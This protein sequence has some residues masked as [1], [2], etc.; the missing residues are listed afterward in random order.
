MI[1]EKLSERVE[2]VFTSC[3]YTFKTM[4][5]VERTLDSTEFAL[6]NCLKEPFLFNLGQQRVGLAEHFLRAALDYTVLFER[7]CIGTVF[8]FLF[9]IF[10]GTCLADDGDADL[11]GVGELRLHGPGDIAAEQHG[12]FVVHFLAV[13]DDAQIAAGLDGVGFFHAGEAVG[14]VFQ[15]LKP[16][17]V[18]LQHFLAGAGPGTGKRI[19]A[20]HQHVQYAFRQLVS[21]VRADGVDNFLRFTV[22]P[23]QIAADDGVGAFHLVIHRLA[24][25]VQQTDPLGLFLVHPQL[26]CHGAAEEGHFQGVLENVLA[27]AGA[28]LEPA[29]QVDQL[30]VHAVGAHVKG[31]LLAGLADAGLDLFRD[32]FDHLFNAGRVD[33]AVGNELLQGLPGDFPPYRIEAGE[34]DRLRGVVDDQVNEELLLEGK[35][36]EFIINSFRSAPSLAYIIRLFLSFKI[37]RNNVYRMRGNSCLSGDLVGSWVFP[38]PLVI[39]DIIIFEDMIHYTTVK[40][41]MFNGVSHPS[42][43]IVKENGEFVLLKQFT[44]QDYFDR[45][46]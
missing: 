15:I 44:H 24:D 16:L 2:V 21:V 8:F 14:D 19:R 38:K 22:F 29:D 3:G 41:T 39:G 27:I 46:C 4:P 43:G 7:G 31:G 23:G 28:V 36:T 34:N 30:G 42:I 45:M 20:L 13:H 18:A 9:G 11:A 25:V 35:P 17:D 33:A 10:H 5:T 32:F 26:G 12:V 6:L 37:I 40:T 1:H